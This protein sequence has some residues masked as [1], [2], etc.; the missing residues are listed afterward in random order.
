[1]NF[2]ESATALS[3]HRVTGLAGLARLSMSVCRLSLVLNI[4][5]GAEAADGVDEHDSSG[6]DGI[7]GLGCAEGEV[8]GLGEGLG[9]RVGTPGDSLARDGVGVEATWLVTP[10]AP[11]AQAIE[12]TAT[13]MPSPTRANATPTGRPASSLPVGYF[14]TVTVETPRRSR[15]APIPAM[16]SCTY[17]CAERDHETSSVIALRVSQAQSDGCL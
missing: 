7:D 3:E 9:E 6:I 13:A 17:F 5:S 4:T 12:A 8:A 16:Y 1:M 14:P 15:R 11:H 10:G 2:G